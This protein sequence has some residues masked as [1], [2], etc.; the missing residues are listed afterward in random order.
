M[1]PLLAPI[2]SSTAN[3]VL[4]SFWACVLSYKTTYTNRKMVSKVAIFWPVSVSSFT[5]VVKNGSPRRLSMRN[6]QP[7]ITELSF[8]LYINVQNNQHS[9]RQSLEIAIIHGLLCIDVNPPV[10]DIWNNPKESTMFSKP[11]L[12]GRYPPV[13]AFHLL[14]CLLVYQ[15]L[16]S[17]PMLE[18]LCVSQE[19][20][21]VNFSLVGNRWN[22]IVN[23]TRSQ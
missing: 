2:K 22:F 3:K 5:S 13:A 12:H 18:T 7:S 14:L 4:D 6:F 17:T 16:E 1:M 9:G 19:H 11:G 21:L 15:H 10:F 23:K 8:T 20:I